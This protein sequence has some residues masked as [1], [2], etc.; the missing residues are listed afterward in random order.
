MVTYILPKLTSRFASKKLNNAQ[1]TH[2]NDLQLA[3]PDITSPSEIDI[4]IGADYYGLILEDGI[5]R[6]SSS[7][8]TA[9]A[10]SFGWILFGPSNLS[11]GMITSESYH[12]SLDEELYDLLQNF[13]K[14]DDVPV[15]NSSVL[16]QEDQECEDHFKTTHT[17]DTHGHYIVRYPLKKS[18]SLLGNSRSSAVRML[19]KLVSRMKSDPKLKEAYCEF[20]QIYED[21]KHM[22]PVSNSGKDSLEGAFYLSHHGIIKESSTTTRLRAVFNGSFKTSTGVSLNDLLHIGAKLQ[23]DILDVLLWFRQFRYVFTSDIEKMYRQ[24][25]VHPDD[26]KLQRILWLDYKNNIV[27]YQLTTVTYGLACAPFLALRTVQKLIEDEGSRFPSAVPTLTNGRYVDDTFGGAH[28]IPEAQEV[29]QQV[30]DL[31][32]AGGFPLQKWTSNEPII[33]QKLPAEK[34]TAAESRTID[35]GSAMLVHTLGM[36]WNPST[37]TF[38]FISTLPNDSKVTKRTTLSTIFK[39]Y[40]PLGL[41]APVVI[42]GKILI[43]DLWALKL[44]WDEQLPQHLTV[45]WNAFMDQLKDIN[46]LPFPRWIKITPHASL[47]LHVFCDASQL[48]L[49]A[50]VYLRSVDLDGKVET[51]LVCAKTKV[52]PIKRLT[53]PRLELSA[54]VIG[55][56]LVHHV[57]QVLHL[58]KVAIHLWTDSAITYTW[59][60]PSRWKEFVH[61]RV[62]FIQELIPTAKWYFIPGKENPADLAT[63]G[64]SPAE[65]AQN[66]HWWTGPDWL[67]ESVESWPKTSELPTEQDNLE[68][69]PAARYSL[70]L[71]KK[72]NN[73]VKTPITTQELADAKHSLAL[74]TQ[75]QL[76][77][78][79]RKVLSKGES[80]STTHP[81]ARLTPFI[82]SQN[83][84]RVGGRLNASFLPFNSKHPII[85]PRESPLTQ[86][87][88]SDAHQRTLHGGTQLTLS[89]TRNEFWILGGRV[90]ISSFIWKCVKCARQRK[91]RGC[92]LMGQLP[93]E[94][95]T[96]SRL[97][98]HSGVDYAGPL[99]LKTW[100]GRAARTYKAYIALFICESTAAIHLELVTDYSSDAFIAAYKRFTA[101]RG[102]CSTLRSDCG[103][104]LT[105]T[106]KELRNLFSSA[107]KELGTMSSLLAKDGT[108]WSFNPPAAPHFGGLWEAGVKSVKHHLRR[109]IGDHLLTYEEMNTFLFQTEAVLNSRPL[110]ALTE[111]AEDFSALTPGHFL[112]GGPL[113]TIPEPNLEDI[114]TARLSRWQLLRQIS[115][116]LLKESTSPTSPTQIIS[117]SSTCPFAPILLANLESISVTVD[118][119]SISAYFITLLPFPCNRTVNIFSR[120]LS[121]AC[122]HSARSV[123]SFD[124]LVSLD[125]V[126]AIHVAA[127]DEF[128]NNSPPRTSF[129]D[130]CFDDDRY[131]SSI[132]NKYENVVPNPIVR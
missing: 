76:F 131:H 104:T 100:K 17:R 14:L 56:K 114:K 28:S 73:I 116:F 121:A 33:L 66:K 15:S 106:D 124:S 120:T 79:E 24:I 110:S 18:T 4:I 101:R 96:P 1:W 35:Q 68:E 103:T 31:C 113:M 69:R 86:L 99:L 13:W 81:L 22:E 2:L 41:L 63:R 112:I 55:S 102:I 59:I 39:L 58:E 45:K 29:V 11:P 92:Q 12:V 43:Q 61:N 57:Q 125:Y 9:Q 82:D 10:T 27:D 90:P 95:V 44:G 42:T 65:L 50:A 118:P 16:S 94:R 74:I 98:L 53:I 130:T 32:E 36:K 64:I 19:F 87:I 108:Q 37:D 88:I 54:A 48:A 51:S 23:I 117:I 77:Q 47:E 75:Q 129:L 72:A 97:F 122:C 49:S 80:L 7:S 38:H 123:S 6:G 70:I 3:D 119:S 83:L 62:C 21:L 126:Y 30:N 78:K 60:N 84:M 132:E 71:R 67:Q 25:K 20:L 89:Y 128:P 109:V 52:A 8:P 26:Q 5:R 105:G 107:S 46:E 40:D 34:Q 127:Y 111:D 85:L 91:V 93:T 115:T